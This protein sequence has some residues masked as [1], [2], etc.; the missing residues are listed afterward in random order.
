MNSMPQPSELVIGLV[1]AVG[2]ELDLVSTD[3]EIA[4]SD[5]GYDAQ[6]IRLSRLLSD[7]AWD[8]ELPAEPLDTHI[9]THME[10]GN[11]LRLC[12]Q[13]SDALALLALTEISAIREERNQNRYR[14]G[15]VESLDR[16]AFILRSLKHPGEVE[17]LRS[18]YG[19]RF[20]LV[21]AYAPEEIRKK[22][23]TEK[24]VKE[25]R[26]EDPGDWFMPVEKLMAR[27][28]AETEDAPKGFLSA[29]GRQAGE[30]APDSPPP[31]SDLGLVND[32][33]ESSGEVEGDVSTPKTAEDEAAFTDSDI[34]RKIWGQNLRDTFHRADLFVDAREGVGLKE[35]VGRIVEILFAH[36]FRT[37]NK[38]EY[39]LFAAEGAARQSAEL[40][41]Q[42]GAAIATP[43]GDVIALGSNEVPKAGGGVYWENGDAHT[44]C[45]L[46]GTGDGREFRN[47]IDTNDRMKRAIALEIID[48]LEGEKFLKDAGEA[49][50][51]ELLT[52]LERTRLGDLIEFGRAVHAEMAALMDAARRGASVRGCTLYTTTFPCHNCARHIVAAGIMRVVY[53]SPYS[54]SQAKELHGDAIDFAAADPREGAVQFEPFVGVAP[55]RYLDLFEAASRKHDD[56]KVVRHVPSEASLNIP[57]VEL[58]DLQPEIPG[59]RQR[60]ALAL[61]LLNEVFDTTGLRIR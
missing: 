46:D 45:G 2:A 43:E 44:D 40:G 19:S 56:G 11:R 61:D 4:L 41:R 15:S 24:L 8:E 34:P 1:G 49:E 22:A 32:D 35:A 12:W 52:A 51:P 36:P 55:R 25:Y 48:Q 30:N 59:Y 58:E 37:P 17:L 50:A 53:V 27:D 21:A 47:Q 6:E 38:D 16:F 5:Y 33:R 42:V 18:I 29:S 31:D 13:R 60:E 54:K 3:I 39:G 14:D 9:W 23:L 28:E 26:S 20:V 57:D 10:A 7:L